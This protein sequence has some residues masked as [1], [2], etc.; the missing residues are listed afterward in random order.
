MDAIESE[1]RGL[2]DGG[3]FNRNKLM[4]LLKEIQQETEKRDAKKARV[5]KKDSY[6]SPATRYVEIKRN[7]TCRHCGA[8]FSSIVQ[9][10]PEESVPAIGKY[11]QPIIITADSP[12]E[13][14]CY[15]GSCARCVKFVQ[16]M[17]RSELEQRYV[18]LISKYAIYTHQ[19]HKPSKPIEVRL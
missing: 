15:V 8:Q 19:E 10:T 1:L 3:V 2:L 16:T 7:Y 17:D 9:L 6:Q 5:K 11:G 4:L 14:D 12:C 13:I 18:A